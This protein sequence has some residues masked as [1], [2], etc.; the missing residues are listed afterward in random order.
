[1]SISDF[2]FVFIVINISYAVGYIVGHCKGWEEH[3]AG[4]PIAEKGAK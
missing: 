4:K 2:W 3:K 1:M